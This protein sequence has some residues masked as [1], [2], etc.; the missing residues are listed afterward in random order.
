MHNS[1]RSSTALCF[2]DNPTACSLRILAGQQRQRCQQSV[3]AAEEGKEPQA[4]GS[5]GAVDKTGLKTPTGSAAGQ[6]LQ[7]QGAG[8][9][10]VGYAESSAAGEKQPAAAAEVDARAAPP[11]PR[12]PS[13][14]L[15]DKV[16]AASV[17]S[18][19]GGAKPGVHSL[20]NKV[21]R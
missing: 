6:A 11:R 17:S 10:Q 19:A 13:A 9:T 1:L 15:W 16:G 7:G 8:S 21:C 20:C 18:S 12:A 14:D 2:A 3:H 5:L 4:P